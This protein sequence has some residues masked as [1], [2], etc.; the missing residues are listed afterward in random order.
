MLIV[1]ICCSFCRSLTGT[2]VEQ[3]E[4]LGGQRCAPSIAAE[5]SGILRAAYRAGSAAVWAEAQLDSDPDNCCVA[6]GL[7]GGE[8]CVRPVAKALMT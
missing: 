7:R 8:D 6:L 1:A 3:P 4:T 5:G 2:V